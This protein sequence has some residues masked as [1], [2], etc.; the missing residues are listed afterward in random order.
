MSVPSLKYLNRLVLPTPA[1]TIYELN[2]A[3]PKA[4]LEELLG[5]AAGSPEPLFKGVK[6]AKPDIAFDSPQVAT[7]LGLLNTGGAAPFASDQSGGNVD[8]WYQD[9]T[10]LGA[11]TAATALS[12][13]R[14]RATKSFIYWN[15]ISA[16]HQQDASISCRLVPIWDGTN[17]PL[18]ALGALALP[19]GS[20]TGGERFTM[21]PIEINGVQ[22]A[23]VQEW[24]LSSGMKANEE[25]SEGELYTSFG[26]LD[27]TNPV[28]E[29]SGRT[30]DWWNT[31]GPATGLT[32]L[33]FYLIQKS[34]TGN[35][36]NATPS[37]IKF[38]A[39]VGTVL[40]DQTSGTKSQTKL[41]VSIAAPSGANSLTVN[42]ASAI[43]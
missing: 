41:R 6:G 20:P 28:L 9:S 27:T 11:R 25:G 7:L 34:A 17:P 23:G 14:F 5:M 22:L 8:L 38:T 37:H 26:G 4:N 12:H 29:L 35:T 15:R 30:I 19:T 42:T 10:Q 33:V 36:P 32:S 18:Q 43:V 3:T 16:R 39:S 40:T 1:T 24:N 21:G 31:Y 2:D 13:Q